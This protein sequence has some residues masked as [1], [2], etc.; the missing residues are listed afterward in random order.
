M[1]AKKKSGGGGGGSVRGIL[2]GYRIF[3]T[4]P[5]CVI[6]FIQ[7]SIFARLSNIEV[8]PVRHS[9]GF[10]LFFL[11]GSCL[12][13]RLNNISYHD[14]RFVSISDSL[15]E[16]RLKSSDKSAKNDSSFKSLNIDNK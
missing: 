3:Y 1:S 14:A 13:S 11:N 15:T 6:S 7:V 12:S 5:T 16:N 4:E 2:S 10:D 8:V 9:F